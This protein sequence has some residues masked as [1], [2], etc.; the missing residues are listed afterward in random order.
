[1]INKATS[2]S[3]L[4]SI[5][6]GSMSMSMSSRKCIL[7]YIANIVSILLYNYYYDYAI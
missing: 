5:M 4:S 3:I 7:A 1:M 2:T 6:S